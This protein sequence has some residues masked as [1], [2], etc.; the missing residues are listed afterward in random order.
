MTR[1]DYAKFER[2]FAPYLNRIVMEIT[3][4]EPYHETY[5][6]TKSEILRKW[7][8]MIAIDDFGPATAT[9]IPCCSSRRI[10]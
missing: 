2:Q 4:N 8:G 5:T 7:G 6:L 10:S 1:A 9:K 3:E